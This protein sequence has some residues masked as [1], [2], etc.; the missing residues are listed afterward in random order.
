MTR[1]PAAELTNKKADITGQE[2]FNGRPPPR[3]APMHVMMIVAASARGQRRVADRIFLFI[4]QLRNKEE[5]R[6][7]EIIEKR[8]ER[9]CFFPFPSFSHESD[10]F[11]R[12]RFRLMELGGVVFFCLGFSRLKRAEESAFNSDS[13]RHGA[14]EACNAWRWRY[15]IARSLSS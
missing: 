10:L 1:K 3:R 7:S 9:T 8:K 4:A 12:K 11:E 13:R 5:S 6:Q 2:L 15:L 14:D